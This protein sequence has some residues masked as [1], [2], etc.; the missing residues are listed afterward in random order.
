MTTSI[1]VPA[2][3]IVAFNEYCDRADM[4]AHEREALRQAVR[5]DFLR[6]GGWV[7]ECAAVYRF[8]DATWGRE[9]TWQMCCSYL[10][11]F[12]IFLRE[13]EVKRTGILLLA[14]ECALAQGPIN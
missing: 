9:P 1:T 3:F 10:A 5:A 7:Q 2:G 8:I 6:V 11:Q 12:R 13:G 4:D 14:R